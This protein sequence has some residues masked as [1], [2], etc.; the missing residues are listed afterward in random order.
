MGIYKEVT[1]LAG[2][3]LAKNSFDLNLIKYLVTIV[4]IVTIL[5]QL[6]TLQELTGCNNMLACLAVYIN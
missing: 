5:Y 3:Q 1:E 6:T 2:T 4:S